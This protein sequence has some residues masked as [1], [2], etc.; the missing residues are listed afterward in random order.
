MI[1]TNALNLALAYFQLQQTNRG[2]Q[3][4]DQLIV[5]PQTDMSTLLTVAQAYAQLGYATGLEKA[6]VRLVTI[7]PD[8]PEAWYDLA[9]IQATLSK[10]NEAVASLGRAVQL[11]NQRLAQQPKSKNLAALATLDDKFVSLRTMPQF[12]GLFAPK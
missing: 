11:S 12:R 8:N 4:L 3:V 2:I 9:A 10:T 1:L 6:L 5:Q 7:A